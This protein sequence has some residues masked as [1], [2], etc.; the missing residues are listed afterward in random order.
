MNRT[1]NDCWVRTARYPEVA[2]VE[3]FY[4]KYSDFAEY[5]KYV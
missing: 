1:N 5:S 4:K 2:T 3:G